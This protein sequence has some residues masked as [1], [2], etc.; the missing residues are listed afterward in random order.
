PLVAPAFASY[1]IRSDR[2]FDGANGGLL[3]EVTFRPALGRL[4]LP[5]ALAAVAGIERELAPGLDAQVLITTRRSSRL[6]TLRVP[7][8]TGDLTVDSAGTGFYREV[9]LSTR[10]RWEN[11]QQLF[12]SY[13]RS[14]A[15]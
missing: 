11:D 10:R 6:A 4:R 12:V 15:E 8:E 1:P 2:W 9:Q 14:S 5:R 13:V 3:R 7:N